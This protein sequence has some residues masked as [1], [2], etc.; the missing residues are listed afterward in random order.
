METEVPAYSPLQVC[1]LVHDLDDIWVH[2]TTILTVRNHCGTVHQ[3]N[4]D[5]H[6]DDVL[7][8]IWVHYTTM[9]TVV[10]TI[11]VQCTNIMM[12]NMK[13]IH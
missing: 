11:V 1:M 10:V 9:V 12:M 6:G 13:M 5:D 7:D 8:D 2:Y 3:H 4:D